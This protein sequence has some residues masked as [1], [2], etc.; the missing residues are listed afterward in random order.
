[1]TALRGWN[2]NEVLFIYGYS[3]LSTALFGMLA[4]NLYQFGDRYIIKGQ[5]DRVLLRPLNSLSQVLFESFN[6]DSIGNIALGAVVITIVKERLGMVFSVWD[7]LWLVG[8]AVSGGVILLSFFVILASMSFH[9]EDRLGITAP[10]YNML[11]FSRYPLT[12]FNRTLQFILSWLIPFGFIAFYPA[13]HF[14]S[15]T[16]FELFCYATPLVAV[17][18]ASVAGVLWTF[19]VSRYASTGN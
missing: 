12:I 8:S 2:R 19:G 10:F 16:G 3:F 7:W 5:F 13:T 14:F 9:F 11:Q 6:L 18:T 1:V 15:R 4:P 17:V